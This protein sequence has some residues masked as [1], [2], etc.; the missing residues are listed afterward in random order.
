MSKM[1]PHF[2]LRMVSVG[3]GEFCLV[4]SVAFCKQTVSLTGAATTE[5]GT[6]TVTSETEANQ[7][8]HS[9]KGNEEK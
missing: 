2:T 3:V 6:E 4:L 5:E 7:Q 1:M 8:I 9:G